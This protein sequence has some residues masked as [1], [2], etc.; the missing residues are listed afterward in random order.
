MKHRFRIRQLLAMILVAAQLLTCLSGCGLGKKN[1]GSGESETTT[2]QGESSYAPGDLFTVSFALPDTATALETEQTTLPVPGQ[3][4]G[5][6]LIGSL[7]SSERMS[8]IFLGYS[9]DPEGQQVADDDDVIAKD[10]TLYPIFR[11][12]EGM[13]QIYDLNYV[14]AED[15]PSAFT[16]DL[17]TYGVSDQAIRERITVTDLTLQEEVPYVLT[18]K[19]RSCL[20]LMD[21][22][23]RQADFIDQVLDA[24]DPDSD[25]DMTEALEA[26]E[27]DDSEKL[28]LIMIYA[29]EELDTFCKNATGAEESLYQTAYCTER[30]LKEV[31]GLKETDSLELYWRN[32]LGMDLEDVLRLSDV[33]KANSVFRETV[34]F[35]LA[36]EEGAWREGD[37]FQIEILDTDRVRFVYEDEICTE[38]ILYYNFTTALEEV[39]NLTVNGDVIFLPASEVSGVTA[40]SMFSVSVDENG[41]QVA[42]QNVLE[43]V[44]TYNGSESL[45]VGSLV[46][47]YDGVLHEDRSVDGAVTYIEITEVQGGG[48]YAYQG[49]DFQDV[50]ALPKVIPVPDDGSLADGKIRIAKSDL[51]IPGEVGRTLGF[52]KGT[53]VEVGDFLAFYN[54]TFSNPDNMT[55]AGYAKVTG[56]SAVSGG[57]DVTYVEV[58]VEEIMTFSDLAMSMGEVTPELSEADEEAIKTSMLEEI[59][60]SNLVEEASDYLCEALLSDEADLSKYENRD[61]LESMIFKTADGEDISFAE[62]RALADGGSKVKVDD[63]DVT[64]L[65]GTALQHFENRIGLRAEVTVSLTIT[66]ALGDAGVLEIVPML[67][68]EQEVLLSPAINVKAKYQWILFIPA[69]YYIDID[70]SF[71]VGTYTGFGMMVTVMTKGADDDDDGEF[72]DMVKE[73][74]D[75]AGD[76]ADNRKNAVKGLIKS[77]EALQFLADS[78]KGVGGEWQGD[79]K[80]D[81]KESQQEFKSPG[82]G[83][84]LP[85]KYSAMLGNDAEYIDLVNVELGTFATP[86]DPFHLIEFSIGAYFV[87]SFKLNAMIGTGITYEN[88]KVYSYHVRRYVLARGEDEKYSSQADLKTPNF[89]ADF[90]AF[91]MIGIR[92][93]IRIDVRL[94]II[95]TKLASIGITAEAGLYAELY[96]FLYIWYEWTSGQGSTS[97]AMGSLLF[98]IGI[99]VEINFKAQLGDGKFEKEIELYSN[100]WPLLQLGA[101]AV[102]VD[103]TIERDDDALEIEYEEGTNSVELPE[104]L[105]SINV[106]DMKSGEVS[107]EDMDAYDS[108]GEGTSFTM[109]GRTYTQYDEEHFL[110]ECYDTDKDG[111]RLG[112]CSFMYLPATNEVMVK[113]ADTLADEVWGEVKLTYKNDTFGFNTSS[114]SRTVK[115]HWEGEPGTASVEYYCEKEPGSGEYELVAEGEFNGFNGIEYD[116]IVDD[117][118]T[119]KYEGYRLSNVVFPDEALLHQRYDELL[120]KSW[121]LYNHYNRTGDGYDEMKDLSRKLDAAWENLNNFGYNLRNTV[122]NGKGTLY[123]MMVSNETVVKVYYD[124]VL[125]DVTWTL[126]GDSRSRRYGNMLGIG[127]AENVAEG[128]TVDDKLDKARTAMEKY[129]D[130]YDYTIEYREGKDGEVKPYTPDLKMGEEDIYIDIRSESRMQKVRWIADGE[131][132][133]TDEVGALCR[134]NVKYPEDLGITG[135]KLRYWDSPDFPSGSLMVQNQ[136]LDM[137]A[138][139]VDITAVLD[140]IEYKTVWYQDDRIV[141]VVWV[142]YGTRLAGYPKI[143]KLSARNA[144]IHWM[145]RGDGQEYEL[146]DAYTMPA[147][148]LELYLELETIPFKAVFMDGDRTVAT[149]EGD[150]GDTLTIPEYADNYR[151]DRGYGLRW[152]RKGSFGISDEYLA[153]GSTFQLRPYDETFVADWYCVSHRWDDGTVVTEPKCAKEGVKRY[154]CLNCG[155]TREEV[156][157]A[158]GIHV[159]GERTYTWAEDLSSVTGMTMCQECGLYHTA[160]SASVSREETGDYK[161]HYTAVFDDDL[162]ETQVREIDDS[163]LYKHDATFMDGDQ[164]VA[165]IEDVLVGT[166]L[167]IPTYS[168]QEQTANGLLL[169]WELQVVDEE[170]EMPIFEPEATF[171]MRNE[172][173]LFKAFRICGTHRWDEGTVLTAATCAQDGLMRYTCLNCGETREEVIPATGLHTYGARS[174]DWSGDLTIVYGRTT[175]TVCGQEHTAQSN[176]STSV[177][178]GNSRIYTATFSDEVFETQTKEVEETSGLLYTPVYGTQD[179]SALPASGAALTFPDPDAAGDDTSL[180]ALLSDLRLYAVSAGQNISVYGVSSVDDDTYTW[181]Q[182][183][184]DGA[185]VATVTFVRELDPELDPAVISDLESR[186]ADTYTVTFTVSMQP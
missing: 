12:K 179:L 50:I 154:T 121:D 118:F 122:R 167:T 19:K 84:D 186:F 183:K 57:Y 17:S 76:G 56:V 125:H 141:G 107:E 68:F 160:E 145:I 115:L 29:P 184:T 144:I 47:V 69:L 119:F 132:I 130:V 59:E 35:T 8:N 14:G 33:V 175:C 65:L 120:A 22:T 39:E 46:A 34:R 13:D 1:P 60:R 48:N 142:P 164:V 83:G 44:M 102:P 185:K 139:D 153:P 45:G 126:W 77:G 169:R 93:G 11:E 171:N 106:M 180:Y 148:N 101:E 96:G 110:I 74:N 150:V 16:L 112:T 4:E 97:G 79:E 140:P 133:R 31:Y 91:G 95:S 62:V 116:L 149:L 51:V 143:P 89:R 80:K 156:L 52:D 146:T 151:R 23:G 92:A 10:L 111:K 72:S 138:H 131:V 170:G 177:V 70:P 135:Y 166:S 25:T 181:A 165:T 155:E 61:K 9:Y 6:T 162:F 21:L 43:G 94:G 88:A 18:E 173:M 90:Y 161:Y 100:T 67:I 81:G 168:N 172:D 99:Y 163:D 157:P 49:A 63:V 147:M 105:Y 32:E 137:P 55:S 53:T 128:D 27:F 20:E 5:G 176:P 3:V 152:L 54:G 78:K 129:A 174:Y 178:S 108:V 37:L 71:E 7:P 28:T 38:Y 24:N 127:V 117:D 123:F 66:I 182:L 136:V 159:W 86:V 15:V 30:E 40:G 98:E 103:F 87:V 26:L 41:E 2:A 109:R 42:Q 64:F 114:I 134:Y 75:A 36:P 158:T 104:E 85:D 124:H 82:V 113:P 58:P 73:Y